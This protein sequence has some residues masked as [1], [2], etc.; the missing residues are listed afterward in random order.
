MGKGFGLVLELLIM[1]RGYVFWWQG[2][3][4]REALAVL[5]EIKNTC[6]KGWVFSCIPIDHPSSHISK[7]TVAEQY[8][9]KMQCELD[10]DSRRCLKPI[11]EKHK[12]TIQEET[13][14]VTIL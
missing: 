5:E 2:L 4:K 13:G 14:H 11:I 10:R 12:L 8:Q 3:D 7:S 6:N 1:C 9:I